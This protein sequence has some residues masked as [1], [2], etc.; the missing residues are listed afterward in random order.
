MAS[1][2]MERTGM[3]PEDRLRIL[4][5]AAPNSWIAL[6]DDESS[7]AGKGATYA[8]AVEDAS[9]NGSKDPILIMVPASWIPMVLSA[10][11]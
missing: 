7:V 10:C 1:S 11:E 6:S 4:Q 5:E 8:E 9:R 3:S 2:P